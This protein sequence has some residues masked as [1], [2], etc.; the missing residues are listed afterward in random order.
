MA[1]DSSKRI[2]N[3]MPICFQKL[4]RK[5]LKACHELYLSSFYHV[6]SQLSL[7]A[8][9]SCFNNPPGG[10]SS[11]SPCANV[12]RSASSIYIYYLQTYKVH[13]IRC[14]KCCVLQLDGSTK[15]QH[16][17]GNYWVPVCAIVGLYFPASRLTLNRSNAV[18]AWGL[19][20]C[21]TGHLS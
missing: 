10:I 18:F 12:C 15:Y 16:L 6:S 5:S 7:T 19:H 21:L 3:F 1:K 9:A 20:H 4:V 17:S 11:A 13:A 2:V 8:Q 14:R